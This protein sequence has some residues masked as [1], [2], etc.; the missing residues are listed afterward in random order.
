[1]FE[2]QSSIKA[3]PSLLGFLWFCWSLT[4]LAFFFLF[5]MPPVMLAAELGRRRDIAYPF[6]RF[7]AKA[8]LALSGVRVRVSG[9]ENLAPNQSYVFVANHY[10]YFDTAAMF[11]YTGKKMGVIAKKELKKLPIAGRFMDYVNI[12]AIDRSNAQRAIETMNF[13]REQMKKGIS[14]AVF[15]EG[16]RAVRGEFLPFKKGAF[17]LALETG[18]SIVPVVYKNTDILMG[19]KRLFATPGVLEMKMLPPISVEGLT[20]ANDL[21]NLLK[22]TRRAAAV[23][24][25]S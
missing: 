7:G 17:H 18:F 22:T 21:T 8:W 25:L 6:A 4:V 20:A 15:A 11:A 10:S 2:P 14:I 19:K 16:T 3:L 23:E 5:L 1:M 9:A 24:I 12:L 13:A